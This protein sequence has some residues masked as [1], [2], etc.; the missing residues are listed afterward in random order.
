[1]LME[2]L[3]TRHPDERP[4][5]L[6]TLAMV[7]EERGEHSSARSFYQQTAQFDGDIDAV[8]AKARLAE[9]HL[10]DGDVAAARGLLE[11]VARSPFEAEARAA[12]VRL[13]VIR[14]SG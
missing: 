10:A 5:V 4:K 13:A 2:A 14:D 11:E 9:L 6:Y 7:E 8:R 12:R 3:A 1:M